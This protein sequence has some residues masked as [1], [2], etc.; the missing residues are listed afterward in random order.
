MLIEKRGFTIVAA[1]ADWPDAASLDRYVCGGPA[2]ARAERS[3]SFGFLTGVFRRNG[4]ATPIAFSCFA[5]QNG[6]VGQLS[7]QVP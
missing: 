7:G 6:Q 5:R 4:L 2:P 1:E 3:L